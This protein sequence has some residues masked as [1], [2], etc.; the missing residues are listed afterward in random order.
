MKKVSVATK[1]VPVNL[2]KIWI[3]SSSLNLLLWALP[4][5]FGKYTDVTFP[6]IAGND[7]VQELVS[8]VGTLQGDVHWCPPISPYLE[9]SIRLHDNSDIKI[10]PKEILVLKFGIQNGGMW[11]PSVCQS[12]YKVAVVI[13]YRNR[14]HHLKQFLSHLHPFLIRQQLD[15]RI[16]VVEQYGNSE[17]NRAKLLNIGFVE[18]LK[19]VD[20]DCFIFHDV[21]LLP[22]NDFNIYACTYLPRHM[23]SAVDTFRYQLPYRNLFGGTIAIQRIHFRAVNGFSNQFYGWGGEDDDFYSRIERK[24]LRIIR[25]DPK[26]ATYIMLPHPKVLPSEDRF[27][28][29][30]EGKTSQDY[31]GLSD[32][33]YEI[34]DKKLYQLYTWFLAAC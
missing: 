29:M 14:T 9:N 2:F 21:D 7:I 24:S 32:L 6:Y 17:F 34:I 18:T 3:I 25:F 16:I 10:V 27:H 22:V 1:E 11:K 31:D 26:I 12:R 13:P 5:I 28:R 8:L 23:Y 19:L 15:Y 30:N 33:S 4:F 20:V